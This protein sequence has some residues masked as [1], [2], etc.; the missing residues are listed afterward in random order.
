MEAL[1]EL[2][3][4]FV[5]FPIALFIFYAM[6][7]TWGVFSKK[8]I[9]GNTAIVLLLFILITSIFAA[10]TGNQSESI[11]AKLAESNSAVPMELIEQHE[12]FATISIWYFLLV[13]IFRFY[14]VIKKKF[15]GNIKYLFILLAIIGCV[16]IFITGKLGGDLVYKYGVG[17]QL[18]K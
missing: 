16:L 13:L 7:E 10:V 6:I 15:E 14:L 18:L 12:T 17:T 3:P 2:H 4:F 5:H 8:D 1:A 11:A 9:F